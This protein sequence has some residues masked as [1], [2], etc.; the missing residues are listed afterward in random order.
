M[1]LV[2]V[3]SPFAGKTAGEAERNRRYLK[4]AMLDS[5]SRGEA[6]YA[7]HAL[8]TQFL[9]DNKPE[10]RKLGMEAGFAWGAKAAM[11]VVYAD[12]GISPGMQVGIDRAAANGQYVERRQLGGQWPIPCV[13][14]GLDHQT[15]CPE[16]EPC[17]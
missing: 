4:A 5:L 7:S 16:W 8:Y 12:L 17:L 6:P 11:V 15:S 2:V 1:R 9:D 14:T 3:E 13:C 10:E